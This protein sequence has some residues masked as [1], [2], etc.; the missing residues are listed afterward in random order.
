MLVVVG[1]Y[2]KKLNE[3]WYYDDLKGIAK[4]NRLANWVVRNIWS[5]SRERREMYK[6]TYPV[7]FC[8][9]GIAFLL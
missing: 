2:L 3:E 6:G 4:E 7:L 9:L 5:N 8:Y 1:Y